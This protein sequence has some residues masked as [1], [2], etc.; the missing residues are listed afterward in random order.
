MGRMQKEKATTKLSKVRESEAYSIIVHSHLR[1]DWV[2]QRPQQFLSR[3]SRNHP[4]LFVE[5]PSP[6][7]QVHLAQTR[8][9]EVSDYPNVL[10][11]Q[12]EMP[13][14]RWNDGAWVDKERRHLVQ[15]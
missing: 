2:W 7:D 13:A 1:W 5:G 3:L 9:R 15:S 6:S 14:A 12:M 10:V 11:L 4:V 8:L